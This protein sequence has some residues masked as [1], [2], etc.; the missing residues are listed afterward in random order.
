MLYAVRLASGGY[1]ACDA[2]GDVGPVVPA[3]ADAAMFEGTEGREEAFVY[4]QAHPGAV[5]VEV[6]ATYAEGAV[7][8]DPEAET[9]EDNDNA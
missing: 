8:P 2:W 5:V 4:A 9:E 6:I 1:L 7:V 3:L